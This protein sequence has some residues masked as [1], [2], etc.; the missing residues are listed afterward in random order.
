MTSSLLPRRQVLTASCHHQET[1]QH[2]V[3]PATREADVNGMR[4]PGA[5]GHAVRNIRYCGCMYSGLLSNVTRCF[6]DKYSHCAGRHTTYADPHRA[7][8]LHLF[9]D[10]TAGGH[11][12]LRLDITEGCYEISITSPHVTP[13]PRVSPMRFPVD[14]FP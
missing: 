7:V 10:P 1:L 11:A 6:D 12:L 14:I 9:I 8:I 13:Y 4:H 5:I 2:L 3:D